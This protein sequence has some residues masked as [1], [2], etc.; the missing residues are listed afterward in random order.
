MRSPRL[1]G[2]IQKQRPSPEL[3]AVASRRDSP[4]CRPH[5]GRLAAPGL[6]LTAGLAWL[7]LRWLRRILSLFWS[8]SLLLYTVRWGIPNNLRLAAL[9]FCSWS[10]SNR[11]L[12]IFFFYLSY[13]YRFG[14]TCWTLIVQG[15]IFRFCFGWFWF[16]SVTFNLSVNLSWFCGTFFLFGRRWYR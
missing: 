11:G 10:W 4:N 6:A 3:R 5:W 7:L 16:H 9:G 1:M 15:G 14:F 13:L 12:R 8:S 2:V